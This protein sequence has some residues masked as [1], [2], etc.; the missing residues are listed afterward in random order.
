MP[1]FQCAAQIRSLFSIIKISPKV[2]KNRSLN[3]PQIDKS[4]SWGIFIGVSQR[5]NNIYDSSGSLY[6]IETRN[7]TFMI[8]L[9]E[10]TN[11]FSELMALKY[12][13]KLAAANGVLHLQVFGDSELVIN[14][15]D[16]RDRLN[17]MF[18]QP[19]FNKV[20]RMEAHFTKNSVFAKMNTVADALSKGGLQYTINTG[21]NMELQD[22]VQVSKRHLPTSW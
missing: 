7:F 20:K 2:Q 14:W 9:G 10:D 6:L 3:H 15:M 1:P 22:G 13:M 4:G 8:G 21:V 12:L 17:T 19:I 16:G 5:N 18:L 11:N